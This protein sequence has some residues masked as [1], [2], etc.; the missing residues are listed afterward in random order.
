MGGS[1]FLDFLHEVVPSRE[2]KLPPTVQQGGNAAV[3]NRSGEKVDLG[4]ARGKILEWI[5][6]AD[7][8]HSGNE[9]GQVQVWPPVQ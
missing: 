8:L 7:T 1:E 6:N 4:T 2:R 5:R 3:G 9:K